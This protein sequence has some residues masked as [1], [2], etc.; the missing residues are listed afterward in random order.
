VTYEAIRNHSTVCAVFP[1]APPTSLVSS[2]AIASSS[3]V[4]ARVGRL[5]VG[6]VG[7]AMIYSVFRK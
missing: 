7:E 3:F 4:I 1:L 5:V 2:P 6:E